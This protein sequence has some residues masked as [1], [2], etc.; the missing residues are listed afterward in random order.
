MYK[1]EEKIITSLHLREVVVSGDIYAKI[2]KDEMVYSS[3]FENLKIGDRFKII[4]KGTEFFV[5][6]HLHAFVGDYVYWSY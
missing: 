4:E 3:Q 2:L 6:K 1:L 5:K